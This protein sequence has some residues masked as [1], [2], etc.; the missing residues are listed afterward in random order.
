MYN[1]KITVPVYRRNLHFLVI[2]RQD[3]HLILEVLN[4]LLRHHVLHLDLAD[5]ES[6]AVAL[7]HLMLNEVVLLVCEYDWN[8][9][10]ARQELSCLVQKLLLQLDA[11]FVC[12]S[13]LAVTLAVVRRGLK[14][15]LLTEFA[16]SVS[17]C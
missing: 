10:L 5:V 16:A 17:C 13:L 11:L 4:E 15:G 14:R 9:A 7:P 1:L 2:L 12:D 8:F 6:C 3:L